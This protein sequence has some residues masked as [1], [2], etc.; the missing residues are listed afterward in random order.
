MSITV[1]V[2]NQINSFKRFVGFS[3][4]YVKRKNPLISIK[5][6]FVENIKNFLTTNKKL[7][8]AKYRVNHLNYRLYQM[9]TLIND[10]NPTQNN[11]GN[12]INLIR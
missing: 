10:N 1:A 11:I 8:I 6:N 7:K 12:S 5:N 4:A 3:V 9:E 2:E